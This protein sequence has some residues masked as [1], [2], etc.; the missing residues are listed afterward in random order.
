MFNYIADNKQTGIEIEIIE[1]DEYFKLTQFDMD[2][3]K[4]IQVRKYP[5]NH[6]SREVKSMA[7]SYA[8]KCLIN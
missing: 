3:N 6:N 2:S 1:Y 5:K 4:V 7:L 8:H